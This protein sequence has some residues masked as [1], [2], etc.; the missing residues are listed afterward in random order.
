MAELMIVVVEKRSACIWWL[1][2]RSRIRWQLLDDFLLA[3]N[4][5]SAN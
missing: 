1:A 4:L 2:I 3:Y 5:R